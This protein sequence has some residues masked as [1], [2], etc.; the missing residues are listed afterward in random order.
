MTGRADRRMTENLSVMTRR[1]DRRRVALACLVLLIGA[2]MVLLSRPARA[3]Q[4]NTIAY[5][6]GGPTTS[7]DES[8]AVA[9]DP[10]S[11]ALLRSNPGLCS[12]EPTCRLFVMDLSYLPKNNPD[13]QWFTTVTA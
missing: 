3:D 7:I 11:H 1:N 12:L 5:T 8:S 10:E 9:P 13:T 6:V 2:G 4:G